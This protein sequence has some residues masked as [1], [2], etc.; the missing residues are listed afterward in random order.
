MIET[1]SFAIVSTTEPAYA[2]GKT[3]IL[4]APDP[5]AVPGAARNEGTHDCLEELAGI[6][7]TGLAV[8]DFGTGNGILAIAAMLRGAARAVAV[9]HNPQA[10]TVAAMQARANRVAVELRADDPGGAFDVIVANVGE[11]EFVISLAARATHLI[12]TCRTKGRAI[13]QGGSERRITTYEP[14]A[15]T[16]LDGIA[17]AGSVREIAPDFSLIRTGS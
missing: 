10:L 2:G 7:L 17:T 15:L 1:P 14:D 4:L 5:S 3:A 9:D 12:A 16:L 11:Q 6:D 13:R 8:L